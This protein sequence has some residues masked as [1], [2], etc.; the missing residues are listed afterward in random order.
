MQDRYDSLEQDHDD[1]Q[2]ELSLIKSELD[3]LKQTYSE[4]I[5]KLKEEL[6]TIKDSYQNTINTLKIEIKAKDSIIKSLNEQFG[7]DE[8]DES[9]DNPFSSTQDI[10]FNDGSLF[11]ELG[12]DTGGR[13]FSIMPLN[14][15]KNVAK[16]Y[17]KQ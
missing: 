12:G 17:K 11:D 5:S 10:N 9:L 1:V 16:M 6:E 15:L 13:S 7:D 14:N 4:E 8:I 2:K 3:S